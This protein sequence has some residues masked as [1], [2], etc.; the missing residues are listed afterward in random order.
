M[1]QSNPAK[2][3]A[4]PT[5][6]AAAKKAPAKKAPAK[7]AQATKVERGVENDQNTPSVDVV[8]TVVFAND[9]KNKKTRRRMLGWFRKSK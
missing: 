9:V 4:A 1:T 7:K 8:G 5:K 3:T 2:K 6:K